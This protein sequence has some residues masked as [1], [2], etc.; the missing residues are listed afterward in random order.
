[1]ASQIF[2]GLQQDCWFFSKQCD[3]CVTS[4]AQ[5]SSDGLCFVIVV[6]CERLA[7]E[8]INSATDSARIVLFLCKVLPSLFVTTKQAT[9][10]APAIPTFT[11]VSIT[12]M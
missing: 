2:D 3:P 12:R 9:M 7:I 4:H 6:K 10:S 5:Q 11:T 8:L 1:M